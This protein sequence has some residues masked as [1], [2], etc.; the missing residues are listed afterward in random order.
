MA[1]KVQIIGTDQL[2]K[3]LREMPAQLRAPIT[4]AVKVSG[5]QVHGAAVTKLSRG[6]A[7]GR[8]YEKYKPRRT[9]QA[10]AKGEPPMTDTG[11]LAALVRWR[12]VD[13]GLAVVVESLAKYGTYLEFGTRDGKIKARPWLFP[14]FEENRPSI[15]QRIAAAIVKT[16]KRLPGGMGILAGLRP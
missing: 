3:K 12:I 8:V 16:L 14:A 9:H 6:P 1:L 7:S 13:D 4:H 10:S 5:I 15:V 11:A 2:M